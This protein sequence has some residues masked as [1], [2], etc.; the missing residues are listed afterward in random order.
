M[1]SKAKMWDMSEVY[2]WQW[3]TVWAQVL[4][5]R[6]AV[7]MPP[8]PQQQ[9]AEDTPQAKP[10]PTGPISLLLDIVEQ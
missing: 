9:D 3:H 7:T 10:Q 4:D 1:L 5:A 6:I 2:S 8:A